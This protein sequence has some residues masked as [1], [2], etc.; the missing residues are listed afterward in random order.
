MSAGEFT[1]IEA[2]AGRNAEA[3]ADAPLSWREF[4]G[5]DA[6][7]IFRISFLLKTKV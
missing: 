4:A 6:A 1:L 5:T 7:H 2:D 3:H